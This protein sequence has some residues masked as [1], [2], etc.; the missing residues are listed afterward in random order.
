MKFGGEGKGRVETFASTQE[1]R[2]TGPAFVFDA[3]DCCT[4]GGAFGSVGDVGF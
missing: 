3:D 2:N 4:E 1:E